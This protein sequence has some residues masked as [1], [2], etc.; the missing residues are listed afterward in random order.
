[1]RRFFFLEPPPDPEARRWPAPPDLLRHLRALRIGPAE[2]FLLLAPGAAAARPAH[3]SGGRELEL[4]PE[5][6]MSAPAFRPVLL[7][8]AW[9]KGARADQLVVRAAE[10]AVERILPLRCARS[11]AGREPLRPARL[12]RW[13]RLAWE[14][15][16]QCR[17][18]RPPVLEAEP[19]P[20]AEAVA[21][22]AGRRCFLLDPAG[23]PLL[24]LL[25]DTNAEPVALFCGPEGGFAPAEREEAASLG[26]EP[27]GLGPTLLRIEAAGPLAAAL[28]QHRVAA[29]HNQP[30]SR[31][32]T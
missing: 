27:A 12:A 29:A 19:L 28:C 22:A 5:V 15:C 7:A 30:C 16:Q 1:M 32:E 26:L 13:R 25:A 18:P 4:G 6:P 11:V 8:T 21:T 23:P 2:E 31:K 9:P 17:N 14:A 24:D 20:L 10:T 3:W